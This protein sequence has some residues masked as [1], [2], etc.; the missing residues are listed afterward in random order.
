MT[1]FCGWLFY[2]SY[3]NNKPPE[4]IDLMELKLNVRGKWKSGSSRRSSFEIYFKSKEYSNRFGIYRGGI[5]GRW[6][7]VTNSL[8]QNSS[9]IVKIYKHNKEKLNLENEV[10]PIYYLKSDSLGLIFNENDYKDG[11][12]DSSNRY[13]LFLLIIYLL[14]FWKIMKK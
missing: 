12:T 9:I 3:Y 13:F 5:F 8:Y 10:I 1:A 11:K 6:T 2:K 4:N 7:K 14:G